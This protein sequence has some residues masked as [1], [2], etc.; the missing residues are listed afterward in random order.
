[1]VRASSPAAERF[2]KNSPKGGPAGGAAASSRPPPIANKP[3]EE[4]GDLKKGNIVLTAVC[5]KTFI[6]FVDK[7]CM[8]LVGFCLKAAIESTVLGKRVDVELGA[9]GGA[10]DFEDVRTA[11][12][13]LHAKMLALGPAFV[14]Y[15]LL[16]LFTLGVKVVTVRRLMS[17]NL[18]SSRRET[19]STFCGSLDLVPAWAF[20]DFVKAVVKQ[21]GP[22]LAAC[23]VIT[24]AT[25]FAVMIE[26]QGLPPGD[27]DMMAETLHALR[28]VLAGC[29][30][31]GV[32]FALHAIPQCICFWTGT[33]FFDWAIM[34]VYPPIMTMGVLF[35]NMGWDMVLP[36][37]TSAL[38]WHLWRT[39]V[40]FMKSSGLFW[41]A[42]AWK[43]L[44]DTMRSSLGRV[45][46]VGQNCFMDRFYGIIHA[47]VVMVIALIFIGGKLWLKCHQEVAPKS[48]VW[49]HL[50]ELAIVV[51]GMNVAWAWVEYM[52]D[53]YT[54]IHF[55]GYSTIGA[56]VFALVILL[57]AT[58][59]IALTNFGVERIKKYYGE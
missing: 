39:F 4:S 11:Q 22:M 17:L 55:H 23:Y 35:A 6:A 13:S 25:S 12:M 27:P 47:F 45:W 46:W 40:S 30:G 58:A 37:D 38:G 18:S 16:V 50:Q 56:W 36:A 10:I 33:Y 26:P 31:L 5:S 54:C 9:E 15:V 51:C 2:K 34:L 24:F 14:S 1:M 57:G 3:A 48:N 32:G 28:K 20:A 41:V 42:W 43:A 44:L 29:M 21:E 7:A 52:V 19:L 8:V 49:D 59:T 53:I